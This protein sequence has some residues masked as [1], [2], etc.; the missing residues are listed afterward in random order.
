MG[1][2]LEV[3]GEEEDAGKMPTILDRRSAISNVSS[4]SAFQFFSV[5]A[6]T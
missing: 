4:F 2:W 3:I 1:Y 5:S 6:F